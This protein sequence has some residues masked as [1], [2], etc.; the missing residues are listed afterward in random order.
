MHLWEGVGGSS[1]WSFRGLGACWCHHVPGWTLPHCR[2]AN[3]DRRSRGRSCQGPGL[4]VAPVIYATFHGPAV[5]HMTPDCRTVSA[6]PGG[7]GRKHV[8]GIPGTDKAMGQAPP[9]H[10]GPSH[11]PKVPPTSQGPS[12]AGRSVPYA[13][14]PPTRGHSSL[15]TKSR[16]RKRLEHFRRSRGSVLFSVAAASPSL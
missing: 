3:E 15:P 14:A 11:I 12:H 13:E 9:P 8:A 1:T 10:R 6:G 4:E 2:G 7:R 16:L 5:S